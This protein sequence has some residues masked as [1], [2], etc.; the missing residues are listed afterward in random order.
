[1]TSPVDEI[2]VL[3][4]RSMTAIYMRPPLPAKGRRAAKRTAPYGGL[5]LAVPSTPA[6]SFITDICFWF[7]RGRGNWLATRAWVSVL[8]SLDIPEPT[9]RT[10]LHRMTK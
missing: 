3:R 10:A 8:G 7:L 1:M 2:E 5:D 9:A 6:N 4:A